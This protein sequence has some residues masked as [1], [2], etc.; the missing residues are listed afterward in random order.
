MLGDDVLYLSVRELGDRIRTR[1]ISPVELAESYLSRSETLGPR[2]HAYATLTRELALKQARA[3]QAEIAAGHYRGPLHGIPYALKDLVAVEG[4]PTTWGARPFATQK[5]GYNATIVE[6]LNRAGSVLVG[7]AAMI[8]LAGGLGYSSAHASFTG[9]ARNPWNTKCWTCGSSSGSGAVVSAALAPWALGSDTRGSTICPAAWCGIAGMR[10]SF[11]R[12]SRY[13]AMAIAWSMDKL[14]PMARTADDCGLVLSVIAGH[15]PR[16]I[17]SLPGEFPYPAP[18]LEP[19]MPLRIGRL[20]NVWNKLDPGLDDAVNAA[21]RVLEQNGARVSEA[22]I[23]DGPYEQVAELTIQMEAVSAF[24]ELIESGRCSEL[25]DPLGKINGY[26]GFQFT[27][28]D[29]LQ[30]QRVR[31]FLQERI[32]RLF[33]DYDLLATAGE[34]SAASAIEDVDD[35][36]E[37][38]IEQRA[39]DGISSLCGLPALSV[40]CGFSKEHLPFGIQFIGR[41]L[42]DHAVIAA[43][44]LYQE[45]TDWHTQRPPIADPPPA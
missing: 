32:D 25:E 34:S 42:N 2:F 22:A 38:P 24:Q 26:A 20:T 43:A 23:P 3:A 44:R 27:L 41:A 14:C 1:Q 35:D 12:V 29:Y 9:A 39:P 6:R 37:D 45:H 7:K 4:Y 33:D 8:E 17:A 5:L 11:G 21:L 13:G 19:K 31:T 28:N 18:E 40:P 16:D 10:P 36:S 15:D 30:V